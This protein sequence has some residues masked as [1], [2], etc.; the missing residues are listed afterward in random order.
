MAYSFLRKK[1]LT[2][3]NPLV[4]DHLRPH[5]PKQTIMPPASDVN[6]PCSKETT[7]TIKAKNPP[8]NAAMPNIALRIFFA[9]ADNVGGVAQL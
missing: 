7:P 1:V 8:M 4:S 2:P 5:I 3:V 9:I 6:P